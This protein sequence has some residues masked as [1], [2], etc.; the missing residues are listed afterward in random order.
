M[1][2][3]AGSG[4][5]KLEGEN[6]TNS[7][8]NL[9]SV[10]LASAAL[11]AIPAPAFA[12]DVPPASSEATVNQ[13]TTSRQSARNPTDEEAIVVTAQKRVEALADVPQSVTVVGGDTLERQ[14]ANNLQDYLALVPGLSLT[15][16]TRGVSR[17]TLR[18]INTGGVASTVGVYIDDVPFGSSSGLANGAILAGDFDTFDVARIEVL[19]GPQGTLYGASSLGGVLKFVTNAPNPRK[20]EARAQASIEDVKGGGMGYSGTAM[21]NVPMSDRAAIRASGFYR[22]EGGFIDS[23]GNNPLPS[24]LDPTHLIIPGTRDDR[25]FNS[26]K[27]YGGRVSAL[28]NATDNFAVRLSADIQNINNAGSDYIEVDADTLKPLYDGLVQSRY[29]PEYTR[30]KYRVYSAVADWNLGFANLTSS[31]SYGTFSETFQR[32]WTLAVLGEGLPPLAQ[33]L[34]LPAEFGG[35]GQDLSAV[36]QQQTATDKFTEE[37]RLASPDSDKFEW[38]LGAFYT[39][40]KSHIDPQSALAVEPLTGELATDIPS[41]YDIF[42]R[43]KYRE[44]AAFAN[45][46]YHFTPRFDLTLGGRISQNKQSASEQITGALIGGAVISYPGLGSKESV[47]TYSIAPRYE[48][49]DN[50]AIYARVASGYRPGGPNALPPEAPESLKSYK[51]DRITSY[52]AGIKGDWF[53]RKLSLDVA[54]FYLDWTDIQLYQVIDGFGVNANGGTAVSKGIEFTLAARPVKGLN[55]SVN[56]AYTDAELTKATDP[57]IGG[58]DGDP[59]PYVP[60]WSLNLNADYEWP[61]FSDWNGFVGGSVSYTGDR[62]PDFNVRTPSGDLKKVPSYT[63]VDLRAGVESERWL[64]QV[65]VKNLTN[66]HGITSILTIDPGNYPQNA[67]AV[68]II[69]PRTIGFTV[70]ARFF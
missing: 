20:V 47:A 50:T 5:T 70:G 18:G 33:I 17:I 67:A 12:Q 62:T 68:G 13:G 1:D 54:A 16:E 28:L 49:D 56:G 29:F 63:T 22:K 2:L 44:Y 65:Y 10:L 19:R 48:I 8:I 30:V 66:S 36:L 25:N 15:G 39:H 61:V 53:N 42:L 32:D 14:Q 57:A 35:F 60:D 41:L 37:V 38:L 21:I 46:T 24:L 34:S 3:T 23:F 43:S 59:L 45:G 27:T 69:R 7:V 6:M 64:A 58:L 4:L 11:F 9:K 55:V 31:T 51:S 26:V 52:E 40:E